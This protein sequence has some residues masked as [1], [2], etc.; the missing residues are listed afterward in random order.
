M[1]R[2]DTRDCFAN[3]VHVLWSEAR[4][5][6]GNCPH[7]YRPNWRSSTPDIRGQGIERRV[8]GYDK[9]FLVRIC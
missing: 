1:Y 3:R 7:K 5:V 8:L 4:G 2:H 9:M 6:N